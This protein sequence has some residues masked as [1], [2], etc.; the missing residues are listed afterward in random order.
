[1][2]CS[3]NTTTRWM[4]VQYP[5]MDKNVCSELSKDN[6]AR[7]PTMI[8]ATK[9]RVTNAIRGTR[10]AHGPKFWACNAKE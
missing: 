1:M 10:A 5:I 9:P 4:M 3:S 6:E 7:H 8:A 2:M